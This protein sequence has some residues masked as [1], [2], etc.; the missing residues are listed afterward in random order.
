MIDPT[1]PISFRPGSLAGP[2]REW[3]DKHGETPSNA[4][5][6][7]LAKLLRTDTPE[8]LVGN[9]NVAE[10]AVAANAAR[11]QKKKSTKRKKRRKE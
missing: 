7:A 6:I 4:I 9:P 11:W 8:M 2:L 1:R 10:Q 5:R 3:C